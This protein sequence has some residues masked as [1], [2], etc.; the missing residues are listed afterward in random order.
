MND[1]QQELAKL[2]EVDTTA[3]QRIWG[4][5]Q[6]TRATEPTYGSK[7]AWALPVAALAA[8]VA[9]VAIPQAQ[10]VRSAVALGDMATHSWSDQV[11]FE[12]EGRGTVSGTD[13]NVEVQWELGTL[14]TE[15]EPNSGTTL[16]IITEESVVKVIGTK[17]SVHRDALGATTSVDH[18]RV[19]VACADGWSGEI[20]A[21]DPPHTCLPI[22]PGALLRRAD[23]L[24]E[25]GESPRKI[26]T[27][28]DRGIALSQPGSVWSGELL[29]RR[30]ATHAEL[31]LVSDALADA[32]AY[33]HTAQPIR[34]SQIRRDAAWLA[35]RELDCEAAL[36]YLRA[37]EATGNDLDRVLL[38]ECLVTSDPDTARSLATSALKGPVAERAQVILDTLENR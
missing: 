17:F 33:L 35:L 27:T 31:G 20:G 26:L 22:R 29:A 9:L 23:A 36:P 3:H 5:F 19:L 30:M 32:D 4:R 12:V 21:D 28:L 34:A 18:G 15:V 10:T 38:A 2:P 25:N 37:L 11:N 16:S 8:A 24:S 6:E 13:R 7:L 14:Y 1:V